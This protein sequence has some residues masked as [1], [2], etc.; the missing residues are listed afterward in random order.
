MLA[1]FFLILAGCNK[2]DSPPVQPDPIQQ[3]DP[4][5]EP[6]PVNGS[7][8]ANAGEDQKVEIGKDVQLDASGSTDPDGD[9]LTYNWNL[10][11][12]PEGSTAVIVG[13]GLV[14]AGFTMDKAGTYKV[15]LTVGD[16]KLEV[17]DEVTITNRTPLINNLL[18]YMDR[19]LELS[20]DFA[21]KGYEIDILGDYFSTDISENSVMVGGIAYKIAFG[22]KDG[23]RVIVPE[24]AVSGD[25]TVTVGSESVTWS[26]PIKIIGLPTSIFVEANDQLEE[27]IRDPENKTSEYFEVGTRFKPLVNGTVE[28]LI[29]RSFLNRDYLVTLWDGATQL[30]LASVTIA[31]SKGKNKVFLLENPIPL[32]AGKEYAISVNADYWYQYLDPVNTQATIFPQIIDQFEFISNAAHAGTD[33]AF[34]DELYPVNYI[35]R[36]ADLIFAADPQ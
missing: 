16:S 26:E 21:Q 20:D 28:G 33:R 3:P 14:D 35:I 12:K 23:I 13:V 25:L 18:T 15:E 2:D 17:K 36:G 1:I 10:V 30:P 19:D 7:P 5:P 9:D 24:N 8:V 32:E 34:P 22:D 27:R 31:G 6:E 29:L 11:E 4:D